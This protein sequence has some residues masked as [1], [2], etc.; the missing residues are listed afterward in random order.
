M[1]LLY[2][3]M[4]WEVSL[5]LNVNSLCFCKSCVPFCSL[6]NLQSM[7][8]I[9]H[10]IPSRRKI[11]NWENLENLKRLKMEFGNKWHISILSY[12]DPVCVYMC[13]LCILKDNDLCLWIVIPNINMAEFN[14][15]EIWLISYYAFHKTNLWF[16]KC[17][18]PVIYEA[19]IRINKGLISKDCH[20]GT[21]FI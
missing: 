14:E 8:C 11:V 1:S 16:S 5:K 17:L 19:L 4:F 6:L 10:G 2:L 15:A 9:L 18:F 21:R 20:T 7:G 13:I 12:A 3:N